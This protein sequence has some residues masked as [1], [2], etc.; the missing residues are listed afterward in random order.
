LTETFTLQ[1]AEPFGLVLD[2]LGKTGTNVPFMMPR[3]IAAMPPEDQIK[4]VIGS[5][6]FSCKRRVEAG[7][8]VEYLRNNDTSRATTCR[9]INRRQAG[10]LIR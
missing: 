4:E 9:G 8:Q 3:G 2:A 1:L 5:G 10:G 6:P 7:E